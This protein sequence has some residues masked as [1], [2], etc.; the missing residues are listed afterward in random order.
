[1][2]I[3]KIDGFA[4]TEISLP[5]DS[6]ST[7]ESDASAIDASADAVESA[8]NSNV[9]FGDSFDRLDLPGIFDFGNSS[10]PEAPK[11]FDETHLVESLIPPSSNL[12]DESERFEIGAIISGQNT[13][14]PDPTPMKNGGSLDGVVPNAFGPFD[15]GSSPSDIPSSVPL[16]SF[17]T[18]DVSQIQT[19]VSRPGVILD[20]KPKITTYQFFPDS[21]GT[22]YV[23]GA[24]DSPLITTGMQQQLVE[25]LLNQIK[26]LLLSVPQDQQSYWQNQ[27]DQLSK[28][29]FYQ[30]TASDSFGNI[31]LNNVVYYP[32]AADEI[33]WQAALQAFSA[34][35]E[36]LQAA[37]QQ[38]QVNAAGDPVQNP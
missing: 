36:Q 21:S 38:T 22:E 19:E 5:Q 31:N 27:F 33:D 2:P 29:F 32:R 20:E 6:I 37:Q 16:D 18:T 26:Q 35:S 13:D 25:D 10:Q 4:G 3:R 17:I 12:V 28:T 14:Q 34:F 7:A 11:P 23:S 15:F 30:A 1:M 24:S 8:N 9:I